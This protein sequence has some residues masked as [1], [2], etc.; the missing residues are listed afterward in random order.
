V[1]TYF[2]CSY[3]NE[4]AGESPFL[5]SVTLAA[6]F[7]ETAG[8]DTGYDR[9]I[10]AVLRAPLSLRRIKRQCIQVYASFHPPASQISQ[11]SAGLF[12]VCSLPVPYY[13]FSK[14]IFINFSAAV[15][16]LA[17]YYFLCTG[18][19]QPGFHPQGIALYPSGKTSAFLFAAHVKRDR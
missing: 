6:S 10:P 8:T 15:H 9:T 3:C 11:K 7:R 18:K 14:R 16:F 5:F 4:F 1:I 12:S 17:S 2:A 19:E 13:R